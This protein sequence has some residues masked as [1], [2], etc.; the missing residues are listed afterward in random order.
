MTIEPISDE[1]LAEIRAGLDGL[2]KGPWRKESHDLGG[3]VQIT[4][5]DGGPVF[6]AYGNAF[7]TQG[8]SRDGKTAT[9]A[10][11]Y[12]LAVQPDFMRAL[13]ARLDKAEAD[14]ATARGL[15]SSLLNGDGPAVVPS[16][17]PTA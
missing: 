11:N 1:R 6:R 9:I 7:S 5:A 14:A 8:W 12:A 16:P 4:A 10:A 13:L 2:P 15:L 3:G 17:N